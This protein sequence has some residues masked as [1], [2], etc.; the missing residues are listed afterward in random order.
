M[1]GM[2]GIVG[3]GSSLLGGISG[4]FG[5]GKGLFGGGK[6]SKVQLPPQFNM[7]GMA[8]AA[9]SALQGIGN[10]PSSNYGQTWLPYMD[11]TTMQTLSNPY[12]G[13]AQA[14]ADRA[15]YMGQQAAQYSAD[16]GDWMRGYGIG[17]TAQAQPMYERAGQAF[18]YG[19]QLV[20]YAQQIGQTAFDPQNALYDRTRQQL[21]EQ[22]RASQSARGLAMTPYGAGL[23]NKA[24][25]DFNIDW[26]NNQLGRQ[27]QGGNAIGG[28]YGQANNL[29]GTSGNLATAGSN[30]GTAGV[31]QVG[32]G[33]NM[34][35]AS[36]GQ[37]LQSSLMPYATFLGQQGDYAGAL[38]KQF[39][40]G[41]QA[42]SLALAPI[43]QYLAYIGAGNQASNAAN[44][45]TQN[46]LSQAT[47]ANSQNQQFGN[48]IGQ[49]LSGL[50]NGNWDWLKTL[51][52][53]TN[54][55]WGNMFGVS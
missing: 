19:Q 36:P 5:G 21:Q 15:G 42:Q 40:V 44:Y 39:Q 52:G 49:G 23:E 35:N 2:L 50:Q 43:Q 16:T 12:A 27:I 33:M 8:G 32:A 29:F 6:S 24:M 10:L 48:Q 45:G 31:N 18:G 13:G 20:P 4:L 54:P 22:T 28:L 17:T 46:A 11:A 37:M 34:L 26:A 7:P 3:A 9:N 14:G 38:G 53:G 47:S 41:G 55:A 1:A 51:G 30:I 25:S